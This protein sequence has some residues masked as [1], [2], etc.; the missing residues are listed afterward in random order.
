VRAVSAWA[1]Q[2]AARLVEAPDSEESVADR[3]VEK[4]R[5]ELVEALTS[6]G[7]RLVL[8]LDV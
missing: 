7:S 3:Q 4:E 1:A 5:R 8:P 6:S 2:E